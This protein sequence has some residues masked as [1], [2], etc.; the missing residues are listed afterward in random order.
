MTENLSI[1]IDH[2]KADPHSS[3]NS[4]FLWDE[5][6]RGDIGLSAKTGGLN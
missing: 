3:F 6:L 5:R 4:W 2:W 1:L